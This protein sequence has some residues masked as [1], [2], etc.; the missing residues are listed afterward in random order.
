VLFHALDSVAPH[1]ICHGQCIYGGADSFADEWAVE[2]TVHVER[3]PADWLPD[4]PDGPKDFYAGKRRNRLMLTQ[5]K[6]DLVMAFKDGFDWE[7]RRGG[8]EDMVKVAM[9]AGVPYRVV[10]LHPVGQLPLS[11]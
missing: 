3:F 1:S 2:R 5:F 8:T 7:F 4:G 9:R 11:F 10:D 6:P